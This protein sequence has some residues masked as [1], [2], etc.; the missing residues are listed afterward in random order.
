MIFESRQDVP[1]AVGLDTGGTFTDAVLVEMNGGRV[2]K[3]AKHPTTHHRLDLGISRALEAVTAGVAPERIRRMAFSTTLAT[4]AVVE[5]R[6][7]R[8][9]LLVIGDV[10]P[11]ELPVVS[12]RYVNG[13]HDH[14]GREVHP[15]DLEGLTDALSELAGHVDAYAVA[16]A[17]SMENPAHEQVAARAIELTDPKPVFASHEVAGRAGFKARAATAV[18]H[19]RL[20]PII[21]GF[22]EELRGLIRR[23][24]FSS[25]LHMIRGD[26]QAVALAEVT[27]RAAATAASG[28]AATAFFGARSAAAR[29]A[30]V[31]D[32]GGTTTDITFIENGKPTISPEGS[33]IGPWR[34]QIEA[35]EMD[36]V[37]IGGDSLTV[38]DRGGAFR[39]GPRRVTP[40]AMAPECP[41]PA[42]WIGLEAR[43][44]CV[45]LL[46][47]G[48]GLDDR[49]GAEVEDSPILH[50]LRRDGAAPAADLMERFRL[51]DLGLER[52]LERLAHR[53]LV[54]VA[55]FTPTDALHVLGKL[56]IGDRN[57][58][59]AAATVL[60][61][62]RSQSPE[63]FCEDVLRETRVRL[64]RAMLNVAFRKRTGKALDACF[65]ERGDD[66]VLA[67][68][69]ALKLPIVALGAAARFLLPEVAEELGTQIIFPPHYEVGNALGAVWIALETEGKGIVQ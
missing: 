36:T 56:D 66:E 46:N 20:L 23:S 30:L 2:V 43:S 3:T 19:A 45:S 4:N 47:D 12:V 40:L 26:A 67:V 18:L 17:M 25:E 33:W 50:A 44:S 35:V 51:S 69:F 53:R 52:E 37:G 58:S 28:P 57:R 11:F 32:V 13:G 29:R 6:G 41:D 16:G 38:L 9:G 61:A 65:P 22:V 14:M 63:A 68:S 62:L 24:G 59:M 7:A 15:L 5:G 54:R 42:G 49:A 60:G 10:K 21:S 8:V 34:T 1:L 55:G 27:S 39:I 48:A 31:V 64:R